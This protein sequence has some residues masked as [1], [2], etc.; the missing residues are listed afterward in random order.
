[1]SITQMN[2]SR[3]SFNRS[4]AMAAAASA[5]RPLSFA[6]SSSLPTAGQVV[7]IIKQHLDVTWNYKTY[8]DTF[9]AGD[10][11]TPVKGIASCFMST[12]DVLQRAHAQGLNFVISHEPTFW[13]D[14]DL[15][16]P[17]KKDALYQEK[18]R[19]IESNGMVV[20][21]IHDHWHRFRP[22]PMNVGVVRLLG[23]PVSPTGGRFYQFPAPVQLKDLAE[24]VAKRLFTRSVRIVGDPEL[25]VRTLGHGGHALSGHINALEKADAAIS[26][27]VREW[28]SVQ[29]VR[30]LINS[31]EKKG[32][33]LISHESG[34]E[35]GMVV[36]TEVMKSAV[37]NIRTVFVSTNDRKYFA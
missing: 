27:E 34:E 37:P 6:Q 14:A 32:L 22:E 13:S 36:F 1:M 3:R 15:I 18:L 4:A 7:E 11:N 16:E 25:M 20:W 30:E 12:L 2:I 5:L 9:K 8:R 33:I 24:Q 31:G 26:S 35:E 21:R 10:P 19:F 28:E 29:Y 17:I 23:W